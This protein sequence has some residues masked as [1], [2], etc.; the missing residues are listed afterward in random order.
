M[1]AV[2]ASEGAGIGTLNNCA[3]RKL[4]RHSLSDVGLLITL[5][6]LTSCLETEGDGTYQHHF[7]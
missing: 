5:P 4:R 7:S 2:S 3:P 1:R 6:I